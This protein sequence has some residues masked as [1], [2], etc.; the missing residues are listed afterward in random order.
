ME[1]SPNYSG[2]NNSNYSSTGT[3]WF[4][5]KDEASD[6]FNNIANNNA[7]KFFEYKAKLLETQLPMVI[8]EF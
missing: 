3:L 6:F 1:Y 5:P 2:T 8:M 4:Y 7:F